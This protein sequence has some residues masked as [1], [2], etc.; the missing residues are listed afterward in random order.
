M[1]QPESAAIAPE[2]HRPQSMASVPSKTFRLCD[3]DGIGTPHVYH[4]RGFCIA[5][6]VEVASV[7][8]PMVSPRN[9]CFEVQQKFPTHVRQFAFQDGFPSDMDAAYAAERWISAHCVEM[10][11]EKLKAASS[12]GASA[13][14]DTGH[15]ASR[16]DKP[17]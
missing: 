13:D 3:K 2:I 4:H 8:G 14:F 11:A 17:G 5:V 16:V 10:R 9:Y 12:G 15:P 7:C 6:G 1:S